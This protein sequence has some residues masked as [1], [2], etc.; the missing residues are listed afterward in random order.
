MALKKHK[1]TTPSRRFM[2]LSSFDEITKKKP[3]RALLK[4]KKSSGGRSGSGRISVRHRGGGHKRHY[5]I[6]DFKRDKLG[7]PAKVAAIE[8]DPNRSANIALLHY[9]DGAKRYI[10]A[11]LGLEVGQMIVSGPEAE[12][13]VGNALPLDRI[14]LGTA[15]HNVELRPG[16]GGKIV[17]SA[18]SSATLMAREGG[19]ALLKLPSGEIRKVLDR[20][21]AT[22]GQMGNTDHENVVS[23]KAG[24]KRWL[25]VRPTVRGVAMNP[26]DHPMGGGEGRSSGGGPSVSPWG[27]LAKGKKTRARR[28]ASDKM[29]VKRRK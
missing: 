17:R 21:L 4:H 10:L 6:I 27:Q 29:I 16:A 5:R 18:G 20:C 15:I 24:R 23:G 3:E 11:P 2:V 25:G 28:K 19:Y 7:V 13:I 12:P 8:Y 14:P 9:L 22:I 26:V 1:P